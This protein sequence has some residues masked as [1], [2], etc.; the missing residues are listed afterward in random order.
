MRPSIPLSRGSRPIALGERA[1]D[2]L[3]FI[4]RTMVRGPAFT[5]VPGWGGVVMGSTGLLAAAVAATRPTPEGW[6]LTWL[7]AAALAIGVGGLH[8]GFGFYIAR[9]HGG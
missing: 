6:L 3:R 7:A 2:D 9:K 4:R 5:A 1:V 8:V